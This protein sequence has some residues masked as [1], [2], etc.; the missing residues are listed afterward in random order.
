MC[1][2]K[3]IVFPDVP[4][5]LLVRLE[6]SR[7]HLTNVAVLH[8]LAHLQLPD[9]IPLLFDVGSARTEDGKQLAYS[10]T[11]YCDETM[12]LEE[13]WDTLHQTEQQMLMESVVQS[14]QKLQELDV[15]CEEARQVL[16]E[17]FRVPRA[18]AID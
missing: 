18:D 17:A 12:A 10:V 8:R 6:T 14:M 11:A 1:I 15:K 3:S 7:R 16:A 13:E 2:A 9:L 5:N 4:K